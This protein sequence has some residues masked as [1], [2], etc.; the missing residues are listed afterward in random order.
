MDRLQRITEM[1]DGGPQQLIISRLKKLA[2]TLQIPVLI[3]TDLSRDIE[4][5]PCPVPFE[6]DIPAHRLIL[7]YVDT[8]L[9]LYR[10]AFL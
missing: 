8:V 9:L 10:P 4:E 5:R 2:E 1:M 7:P 3:T 6:K